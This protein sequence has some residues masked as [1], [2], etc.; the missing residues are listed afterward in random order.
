MY[1]KWKCTVCHEIIESEKEPQTCKY[2]GSEKHKIKSKFKILKKRFDF[3][4]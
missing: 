1:I 2:C 4:D 3:M